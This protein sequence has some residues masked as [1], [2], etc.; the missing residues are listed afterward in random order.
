MSNLKACYYEVDTL[1]EVFNE[2]RNKI[3][4]VPGAEIQVV[5]IG[6]ELVELRKLICAKWRMGDQE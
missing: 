4:D 6:L 2:F 3:L 5:N 1:I